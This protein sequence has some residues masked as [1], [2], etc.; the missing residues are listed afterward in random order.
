VPSWIHS[1]RE[2]DI[3]VTELLYADDTVLV[4]KTARATT[5]LLSRVQAEFAKYNMKLNQKSYKG[6]QRGHFILAPLPCVKCVEEARK[7]TLLGRRFHT[8]FAKV[9]SARWRLHALFARV[10]DPEELG[11]L[12]YRV[13]RA[14]TAGSSELP[15]HN[16]RKQVPRK[17]DVHAL[18]APRMAARSPS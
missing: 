17:W 16:S 6:S 12:I 4:A 8:L 10:C 18:E 9:C 5:L 3:S 13:G 2:Q 14:P 1:W 15:L 11:T 7:T